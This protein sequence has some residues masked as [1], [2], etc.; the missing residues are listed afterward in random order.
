[1]IHTLENDSA[2]TDFALINDGLRRRH[3]GITADQLF[4]N[5]VVANA[6]RAGTGLYGY[7][8]LSQTITSNAE[9]L[10]MS[11]SSSLPPYAA[12]YLSFT[13]LSGHAPFRLSFSA[14]PT[15]P[16][17]SASSNQPFW[18]SNRGDMS[19]TRLERSFD[20]RRTH[21]AHLHFRLW[22][23]LEDGYDFGYVEASTD[24]GR[25]WTT[26]RGRHTTTDKR[27]GENYGNGYTGSSKGW[28]AETINLS[29]FAGKMIRLR[30]ETVTDDEVNLQGMLVQ[31]ITIPEIGFRDS[32]AGWNPHGFVPV[33]DNSL[34]AGWHVRL[35]ENT[36]RGL[37]VTSL[38]LSAS[39]SGALV[40]DPRRDHDSNLTVAIYFTAPK[41]TVKAAFKV[42]AS[43]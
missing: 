31:N 43:G 19:D 32:L 34:P 5:W 9:S 8:E 26:L 12:D 42:T 24:G 7:R 38:P 21:Q 16:L 28:L 37:T 29:R 10:P 18:W 30:F 2:Y 14:A 6:A 33:L 11:L 15:I 4:G 17:V 41:T 25:T 22:Y 20:L 39:K 35:I 27:T 36:D 3:V 23:Q 13:N 1:M 40:V